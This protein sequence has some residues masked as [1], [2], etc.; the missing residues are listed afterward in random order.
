GALKAH[1]AELQATR[2][3]AR[4]AREGAP[5]AAGRHARP[6]PSAAARRACPRV[7]PRHGARSGRHEQGEGGRGE[8]RKGGTG[9]S[10]W[11]PKRCPPRQPDRPLGPE[12]AMVRGPSV[13]CIDDGA[14]AD[15]DASADATTTTTT[16]TTTT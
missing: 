6:P 3:A 7:P 11:R 1:S 13:P 2:A 8:R 5:A 9:S 14:D 16:T 10:K 4:A 12:V 15:A